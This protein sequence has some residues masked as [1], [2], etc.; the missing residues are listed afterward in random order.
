MSFAAL[1]DNLERVREEIAR[2]QVSEG[3]NGRVTIVGI[4]KGHPADA[5]TAAYQA[6][7][8]DIGENRV[9]EAL[10]KWEALS[11]L[12]VRWHLVGHLQ[13]NKA[14]FVPGR[15]SMVHSVD[16]LKV[17]TALAKLI[18]RRP[19]TEPLRVLL[20]VNVSGEFQKSGCSPAEAPELAHRISE[21]PEFKLEG[22]MTLAPLTD[23]EHVS[24]KVFSALRRLRDEISDGGLA[25]PELSMGM[26]S[27]YRVAVAEGA[28]L[29]RLGT[30]LFGERP[31]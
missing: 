1:A 11:D 19:G 28:T 17:A 3:L 31:K 24:R 13:S 8:T 10:R 21:L 25:L 18:R 22:L 16:T 6:G 15:F 9:Q 26:S 12:P 20:Q 23:D 27:D 7:L 30:V 2:V 4:T 29:L 5:I 14:R